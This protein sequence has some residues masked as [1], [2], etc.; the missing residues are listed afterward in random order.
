MCFRLLSKLLNP[1]HGFITSNQIHKI[2]IQLPNLKDSVN[3]TWDSNNI[4]HIFAENEHDLYMIQGYIVAQDRLWQM[5]FIT[6][7]HAGKLSEIMGYNNNMFCGMLVV[8]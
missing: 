3:V 2:K 7:V 1:F 8:C 4:P 6:R 5:D